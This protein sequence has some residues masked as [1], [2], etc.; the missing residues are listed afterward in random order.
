MACHKHWPVELVPFKPNTAH[1]K[2]LALGGTGN[3]LLVDNALSSRRV[4]PHA[5]M[6]IYIYTH[7]MHEHV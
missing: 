5:C 6:Y 1:F 2:S 7:G 3:V 4:C